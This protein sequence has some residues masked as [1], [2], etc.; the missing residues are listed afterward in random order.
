MAVAEQEKTNGG[1]GGAA[2]A[3]LKAAAAAAATGAATYAVKK[4][5]SHDSG[6]DSDESNDS[7]EKRGDTSKSGKSQGILASAAS[8]S[9]EAAADAL[10]PMAE[11]AAEAAGKYVA[12]H[13]PDV[14]RERIIPKFIEAFN[15]AA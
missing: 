1:G 3:A 14:L 12:E 6:G 2:S 7:N 13:G 4:V 9:W 5:R 15:D 10:L 11:D 8:T